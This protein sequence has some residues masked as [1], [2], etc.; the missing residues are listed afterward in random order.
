MADQQQNDIGQVF[1]HFAHNMAL[2]SDRIEQQTVTLTDTI[3]AQ[4]RALNVQAIAQFIKSYDGSNSTDYKR[5]IKDIERYALIHKCDDEQ[6]QLLTFQTSSGPVADYVKRYLEGGQGRTFE[7]LKAALAAGFSDITDVSHALSLL[8]KCRQKP[9]QNIQLYANEMQNFV[10]EAYDPQKVKDQIVQQQLVEFF[11]DGLREDGIRLKIMRERPKTFDKA[12]DLAMGE[13]N[14]RERLALRSHTRGGSFNPVSKF[15]TSRESGH[16]PMVTDHIRPKRGC[17]KC[18]R[19]N[20]TAKECRSKFRGQVNEVT[21]SQQSAE[22]PRG[23]WICADLGHFKKDCPLRKKPQYT[24][25]RPTN[26]QGF[27]QRPQHPL[28]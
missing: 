28:N 17:F 7:G 23:C 27:G 9:G 1:N 18:G 21:T 3:G 11:T 2:I 12:V 13:Q 22:N 16:E 24:V 26:R 19:S 8:S 6:K 25:I 15:N 5:W 14:L 4:T 20:H 10:N